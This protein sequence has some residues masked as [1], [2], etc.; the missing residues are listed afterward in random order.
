MPVAPL[1]AGNAH[2]VRALRPLES[3]AIANPF[4]T[5]VDGAAAVLANDG[6]LRWVGERNGVP[7]V[8]TTP[9]PCRF[10]PERHTRMWTIAPRVALDGAGHVCCIHEGDD[11][12]AAGAYCATLAYD[13]PVR[14]RRARTSAAPEGAGSGDGAIALFAR[15]VWCTADAGESMRF[16]FRGDL[17]QGLSWASCTR[18]GDV[19]AAGGTRAPGSRFYQ[20]V[21]TARLGGALTRVPGLDRGEPLDLRAML[22]GSMRAIVANDAGALLAVR[23]ASG[24]LVSTALENALP[25]AIGAWGSTGAVWTSRGNIGVIRAAGGTAERTIDPPLT[26]P[27][28]TATRIG[29]ELVGVARDGTMMILSRD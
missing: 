3:E 7:A 2:S 23:S 21:R 26:V 6:R 27:L 4:I 20:T 5:A 1:F 24:T 17:E 13:A 11:V 10:T 14:F 19:V 28:A 8:V 16:T 15:D 29:R 12:A 22:D 25:I 9:T 18:A